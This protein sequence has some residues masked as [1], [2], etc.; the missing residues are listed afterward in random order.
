MDHWETIMRPL[1]HN[2]R[3]IGVDL[4][5]EPRG[6]WGTL[7][8]DDWATVAERAAERLLAINPEWLVMV[9]GI[10]SANDLSEVRAR[11]IR[12]R[13]PFPADRVVYSAHVYSWSG[14]G[15]LYP[16]SR[17]TYDDFVLEMRRNWAYLLEENIAPVWVGELG[18][19][20]H[21][22][23]GDLNYWTHL[24]E[25]LRETDVS[26]GYWAMNPRKP[27]ENK[28]EFYGLVGDDWDRDSVRWDYRLE[29]MK[30]LGLRPDIRPQQGV[31]AA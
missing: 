23:A 17:R 19:N 21:P 9:E 11:P 7:H 18:V 28:R 8:W 12:L 13:A 27:S 15:S 22:T 31:F 6:L 20:Y 1:A 16:Y 2:P 4:R 14:W 10:S 24:V 3:V 26:W 25:F 5:N 30:H 29:D